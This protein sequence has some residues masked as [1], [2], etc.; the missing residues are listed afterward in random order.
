M[1]GRPISTASHSSNEESYAARLCGGWGGYVYFKLVSA[2]PVVGV[3][4]AARRRGRI[5]AV[6]NGS[7][8]SADRLVAVTEIFAKQADPRF[9]LRSW[10]RL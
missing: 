5:L 9:L 7:R 4:V 10:F 8:R 1:Y 3:L 6:T 2:Q